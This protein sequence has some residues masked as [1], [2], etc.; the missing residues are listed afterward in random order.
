[1]TLCWRNGRND[2]I[3]PIQGAVAQFEIV[4]RA[5]AGNGRIDACQLTIHPGA[6]VYHLPSARAWFDRRLVA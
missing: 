4:K 6:H 5:Y 2:P 3:F 1:L